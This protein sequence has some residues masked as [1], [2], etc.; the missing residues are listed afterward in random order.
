MKKK[1]RTGL[2]VSLFFLFVF[3][4]GSALAAKYTPKGPLEVPR[5]Y[6]TSTGECHM[7]SVASVQAYVLGSYSYGSY[8]RTYSGAGDYVC[9]NDPCYRAVYDANKKISPSFVQMQYREDIFPV[10][11]KFILDTNVSTLMSTAYN[12]LSRGVPVVVYTGKHASVIIGYRGNSDTLSEK[13]FTVMEIHRDWKNSKSI[14]SS[15]AANP[16]HYR[17]GGY[18]CYVTLNSWLDDHGRSIKALSYPNVTTNVDFDVNGILDGKVSGNTGD[19]GTFD[20][21]INDKLV[22][23]NVNDFSGTYPTGT[24]Y[25]ITNVKA[26]LGYTYEGVGK[27]YWGN[28]VSRPLEGNIYPY[29]DAFKVALAF[30]TASLNSIIQSAVNSILNS[31]K[32]NEYFTKIEVTNLTET[33]AQINATIP[34]QYIRDCGFYFGTDPSNLQEKHETINATTVLIY[35]GLNKWGYQLKPGTTYYYKFW[36]TADNGEKR[37]CNKLYSFTTPGNITDSVAT[38]LDEITNKTAD[39]VMAFLGTGLSATS[40]EMDAY[41]VFDVILSLNG[42]PDIASMTITSDFAANGISLLEAIPRGIAVRAEAKKGNEIKLY[43][44]EDIKGNGEILK[45]TFRAESRSPVDITFGVQDGKKADDTPVSIKGTSIHATPKALAS[46]LLRPAAINRTYDKA[47]KPLLNP[48]TAL[49]GTIQY[50]LGTAEGPVPTDGWSTSI[51]AAVNAG[52]YTVYYQAKGNENFGDSVF[53]KITVEISKAEP[54]YSLPSGLTA[55]T[56]QT[57]AEITLPAGWTWVT[58]SGSVGNAGTN[59]FDACFTPADQNNYNSITKGVAVNV[60]KTII[61]DLSGATVTLGKTAA[62]DGTEQTQTVESVILDGKNI[63]SECI[64]SKNRYTDPGTYT[65]VVSPAQGSIYTGSKSVVYTVSAPL[66]GDVNNDGK[67]DGRDSIRLMKYLSDEIDP[68][69][70]KVFIINS[71]AA[72]VTGDRKVDERDLLRIMRYL[73]GSISAL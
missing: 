42:N 2:L 26:K 18:K 14:F 59:S 73:G 48:G 44:P 7:C 51:P 6:Q 43:S 60:T 63:L 13:D 47:S 72:D 65:L 62:A 5:V 69:T 54:D 52:T 28:Y 64:I 17:N 4:S 41:G 50:S 68:K 34:K 46:F 32:E 20:V 45:L 58:P 15:D 11:M 71:I 10:K 3:V 22:A 67:V 35:Y 25:K 21:Y 49:N 33:N 56:G 24:K 36:Y 37:T 27:Q 66:P 16:V 39:Y 70:G 53:E 9:D 61:T 57:L 30:K 55:K 1:L 8:S 29:A 40:T 38:A 19:W 31:I 23:Q 12:Q